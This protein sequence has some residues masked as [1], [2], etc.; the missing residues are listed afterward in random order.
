MK[1]PPLT[2]PRFLSYARS[3]A[4]ALTGGGLSEDPSTASGPPP[5]SGEAF[6]RR[7]KKGSPERGAGTRSVTEGSHSGIFHR[8]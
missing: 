5:L 6:Q 7:R 3:A 2:P 4:P 8:S 1:E